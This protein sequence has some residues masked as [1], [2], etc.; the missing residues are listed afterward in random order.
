MSAATDRIVTTIDARYMYAGRAA[1]YLL[2]DSGE[3]AFI[4]AGTRF[5][6]PYMMETLKGHGL[7]PADV[8]YLLITHVHLDHSGGA[9]ELARACPDATVICHPKSERHLI[10]PSKL[11]ASAQ[12]VYGASKFA[13]LYGVIDPI[14][15]ERVKAVEDG[16][17]LTLGRRTLAFIDSPGHAPHHFCVHDAA[18][19]EMFTGDAFGLSYPQLQHGSRPYFSYVCSPPQFDP[20]VACTTIRRIMATRVERVYVTHFGPSDAVQLGGEQMLEAIGL[21]DDAADELAAS[22]LEGEALLEQSSQLVLEITKG[23]LR[24]CG[25]DD[26]NAENLRWALS[27]HSV[28]SQGVQVLALRRRKAAAE[29]GQAR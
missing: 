16:G 29:S 25:L 21:F 18:A 26:T 22:D 9:G 19:R 10:D 27:E 24:K 2:V 20:D 5:S 23:E 14:P 12:T 11:L 7:E 1:A 3:A 4:D 8:R 28:T 13:E 17:T 15:A 6:V